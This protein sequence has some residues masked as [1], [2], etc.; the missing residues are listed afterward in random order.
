M[1][2]AGAL[3]RL[4]GVALLLA[5]GACGDTQRGKEIV[6]REFRDPSSLQW[7]DVRMVERTGDDYLCGEVNGKNGFGA[8]VGF[9]K[10]VVHMERGL[11][12]LEPRQEPG[13]DPV[14]TEEEKI[15]FRVLSSPCEFGAA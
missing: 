8:Y 15:F 11:A 7:R 14:L 6:A 12:H 13:D 4:T 9:R 1:L 3:H 5:L 2:S 10:F